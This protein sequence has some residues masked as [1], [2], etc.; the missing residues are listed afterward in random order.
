MNKGRLVTLKYF[1]LL[2]TLIKSTQFQ[3]SFKWIYS[4]LSSFTM[5]NFIEKTIN[6]HYCLIRHGLV[7]F[8]LVVYITQYDL[9]SIIII[10]FHLKDYS[11]TLLTKLYAIEWHSNPTNLPSLSTRVFH[12]KIW[13]SELNFD[14]FAIQIYP[15]NFLKFS[16]GSGLVLFAFI[17]KHIYKFKIAS[18]LN[19]NWFHLLVST[20]LYNIVLFEQLLHI[21][22]H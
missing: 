11:F 4:V 18:F 16:A 7:P 13:D 21:V 2:I 8:W 22:D 12:L 10:I 5:V 17:W 9:S 20:S 1:S 15:N 14:P 19:R 6:T 3:F